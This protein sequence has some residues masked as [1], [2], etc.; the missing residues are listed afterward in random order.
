VL[1]HFSNY[2]LA[3]DLRLWVPLFF[4]PW[5]TWS[6]CLSFVISSVLRSCFS[7]L[8]ALFQSSIVRVLMF[9]WYL[10]SIR[11]VSG[12]K[13][14]RFSFFCCCC[15]CYSFALFSFP[16]FHLPPQFSNYI[17]L[18][19]SYV[20]FASDFRVL[21]FLFPWYSYLNSWHFG[22]FRALLSEFHVFLSVM[23]CASEF[24]NIIVLV[25]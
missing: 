13:I 9:S 1:G 3:L 16:D 2:F 4:S 18:L 11:V 21:C 12:F 5:V 22:G 25:P 15:C 6:S 8:V 7:W 17:F 10:F 19:F 14:R 24:L 20:A 23:D